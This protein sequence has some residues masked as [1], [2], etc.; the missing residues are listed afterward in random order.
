MN[1]QIAPA[2]PA[3]PVDMVTH[4]RKILPGDVLLNAA[5]DPAVTVTKVEHLGTSRAYVRLS[6]VTVPRGDARK[7]GW[8]RVVRPTQTVALLRAVA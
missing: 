3:R 4:A 5:G 7:R 1:T 2:R 6:G 8:V